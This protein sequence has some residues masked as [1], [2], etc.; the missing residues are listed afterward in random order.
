MRAFFLALAVFSLTA[1]SFENPLTKGAAKNLNTWLLGVWE[2]KDEKGQVYRA[3]LQPLTGSRYAVWFR[4]IGKTPR[5]TR[6][7]KF[8]AWI[9]RVGNS[10][11][12]TLQCDESAGEVPP[13][14]FVFLH[15]QVID[16][17]HIITRPLQL[18]S[19]PETSS[20]KLRAEVRKKLKNR[21]LLPAEGQVWTRISEVYWLRGDEWAEQPFQPLRYVPRDDEIIRKKKGGGLD[22]LGVPM[23]KTP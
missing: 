23:P 12:L 18:E 15:Y 21:T 8:T 11:F 7:W 13:E 6:E 14:A 10:N 2:H 16:Q 4:K 17:N 9:S 3:G 20:Y 5:Q 19:P 1:C 22:G